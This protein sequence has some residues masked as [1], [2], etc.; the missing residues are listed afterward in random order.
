[1]ITTMAQDLSGAADTELARLQRECRRLE[2]QLS[3]QGREF[4]LLSARFARYETALRGSQVTVYTQD[5]DLHFTSVSK[6]MLGHSAARHRC[7]GDRA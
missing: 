2:T 1:M 3:A 5:R 7:G 4:S 6:P